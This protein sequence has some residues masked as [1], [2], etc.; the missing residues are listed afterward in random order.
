VNHSSTKQKSNEGS[1]TPGARPELPD[2]LRDLPRWVAWRAEERPGPNG[3]SRV[4]K[5]PVNPATGGRAS[6]TDPF[7]WGSFSEAWMRY[8]E[9]E[10]SCEGVG[11]V[12][13]GDGIVGI[14]L[15][16]CRDSVSGEIDKWALAIVKRIGSYAE[17]SPSGTGLHIIVRS[18]TGVPP[19]G[20]RKGRFEIYERGRYFTCTGGR[21]NGASQ[22]IHD[23]TEEIANLHAEIFPNSRS[24]SA[25]VERSVLIDD[26]RLL[27]LA[28]KAANAPK[29]RKLWK[30]DVS[31]YESGS[32]ATAGLLRI[33]AFWTGKNVEQMDRLFR[34]SG[35]NRP[36]W[37]ETR[38]D[39]TW[40]AKEIEAA[41]SATQ[42][43]YSSGGDFEVD[44]S[45]LEG[46][47]ERVENDVGTAFDEAVILAASHLQRHNQPDFIRLREKLRVGG[48]PIRQW[49]A[50][51]GKHAVAPKDSGISYFE[52]D[53]GIFWNKPTRGGRIPTKLSNF[54]ATIVEDLTI[55]DGQDTQREF[56]VEARHGDRTT[57]MTI[58]PAT[59]ASDGCFI[60]A[61]GAEA[62][63][64]PGPGTRER[65]RAAIQTLSAAK[66]I[67]QSTE[68]RHIGWS[69]DGG[70]LWYLH[71]GGAIGAEGLIS[72]VRV[73]L[74]PPFDRYLLSA[75]P[76]G[77][78][79]K[80][81][82]EAAMMIVD[83]T[84]KSPAGSVLFT[85]PYRAV[86]GACDFSIHV[87]GPT[88]VRKTA[89]AACVQSFFGA[90]FD[91]RSLPASWTSTANSLEVAAFV[92]KDALIVVDDLAPTGTRNDVARLHAQADRVFRAQGNN[93]GRGRLRADASMRRTRPPRG[94]I[95]STG[96]DVPPGA[97][98]RARLLVLEIGPGDINLEYLTGVQ[99]HGAEGLLSGAM[100]AFLQWLAMPAR[101][102][103]WSG[104]RRHQLISKAR[105]DFAGAHGRTPEIIGNLTTGL[106]AFVQFTKDMSAIDEVKAEEFQ[107][108]CSEAL[109]K[110]G[111]RQ[112]RWLKAAEPGVLFL[113]LL[114]AALASGRCHLSS[115]M[116]DCP[117]RWWE[118]GW[119]ADGGE[120]RRS[121]GACVGYL[122]DL[123]D[124]VMLI[125]EAALAA[126]K[127]LGEQTG[128]NLSISQQALGRRLAERGLLDRTEK[129][130]ATA[131]VRVGNAR[132][133][134]WVLATRKLLP[135]N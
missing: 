35:L 111:R 19:G 86:L 94:L 124:K 27:V 134:L 32:E 26:E 105:E 2:E 43:V 61:L 18:T 115:R 70:K 78:E 55:T 38:G 71:A 1:R 119:R 46:I 37:D 121:Q 28:N 67:M 25:K 3:E 42:D 65:I 127:M 106:E 101:H 8:N 31:D 9:S 131:K 74:A 129:G 108:R 22:A 87:S 34:R 13:N 12:F 7:T 21:L 102:K 33:L 58:P 92:S 117:D 5:V 107:H 98:L 91:Q 50:A 125:P 103:Y 81:A 60:E 75:P 62:I 122:D 29:F 57:T 96:E 93:S 23:R 64:E 89:A 114:R 82:I 66:G 99:R 15:D 44:L 72:D 51:I 14:D 118:V 126:A 133:R 109:V 68:H 95:L 110:T 40:G 69:R 90:K 41:I 54:T 30:G 52:R 113:Q 17:V 79:L 84:N 56:V 112:A 130:R 49:D 16:K 36:K 45:V 83:L 24:Q 76:K 48:V 85:A 120:A 135:R 53:G 132:Q 63:V 97:S 10:G 104:E 20:N 77:N 80:E 100:S 6:T 123:N 39:S 11:F 73:R 116:G 88:G 47:V 59:L 4:A 128:D